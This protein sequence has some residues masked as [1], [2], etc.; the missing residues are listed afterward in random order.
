MSRLIRLGWLCW[1]LAAA[2]QPALAEAPDHLE[3]NRVMIRNGVQAVLMCNG[4]FTSNR[5]LEQ[6]F[7]QELAYLF[8]FGGVV[9]TAA[10]GD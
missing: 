2:G 9:G 7:D 4:L 5:T 8:R 1:L 10:G 3:A 6:V